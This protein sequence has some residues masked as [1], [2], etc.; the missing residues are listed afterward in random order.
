[1]QVQIQIQSSIDNPRWGD[2]SG[3]SRAWSSSF[4]D[5]SQIKIPR[6][7]IIMP[8][9]TVFVIPDKPK[10]TFLQWF[11]TMFN[12]TPCIGCIPVKIVSSNF[13]LE[14]LEVYNRGYLERLKSPNLPC[15]H[16]VVKKP[17]VLKSHSTSTFWLQQII[18]RDP[19]SIIFPIFSTHQ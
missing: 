5:W 11:N 3:S 8:K 14:L 15:Q 4:C 13:P 10:Y 18:P 7:P 16:S 2:Y 19:M 6:H 9:T 17:K 1:M 12:C